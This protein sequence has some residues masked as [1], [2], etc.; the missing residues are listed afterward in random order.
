MISLF[1]LS[2]TS[3]NEI[4]DSF[5]RAP[6]PPASPAGSAGREGRAGR[7]GPLPPLPAGPAGP[8]A[9]AGRAPGQKLENIRGKKC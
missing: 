4:I 6:D 5:L 9:G 3:R 8:P 2:N 1:F 7:E